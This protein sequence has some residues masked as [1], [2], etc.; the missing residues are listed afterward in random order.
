MTINGGY[1]M[2]KI[3]RL[4]VAAVALPFAVGAIV[5][6]NNSTKAAD[7]N[8][9]VAIDYSSEFVLGAYDDD[10]TA[11]ADEN[12]PEMRAFGAVNFNGSF[13]TDSGLTIGGVI[14]F[15]AASD[16]T[17]N[18]DEIYAY[19]SGDFGRLEVGDQDGAADKLGWGVPN[20]GFGQV[21]GDWSADDDGFAGQSPIIGLD[22]SSDDTK[23]T[24]YP[25]K[26]AGIQLGVSWSPLDDEGNTAEIAAGEETDQI[27]VG[28]SYSQDFAGGSIEFNGAW[29]QATDN[30][31]GDEDHQTWSIGATVEIDSI[32]VGIGHAD[33]GDS[34]RGEGEDVSGTTLGATYEQG[35][36]GFGTSYNTAELDAA[37]SR[38]QDAWS[39]GTAYTFAPEIN[40]ATPL[41]A[42]IAADLTFFDRDASNNGA[43]AE[44]DGWVAILY[45]AIEF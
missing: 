21:D 31:A 42:V 19:L 9:Y 7:I 41:E 29:F 26:M 25:P 13:V 23:I 8:D 43:T 17:N 2:S 3:R 24:Y 34:G 11:D 16:S 5:V 1:K 35:A 28:A 4:G 10:S 22:E 36:W 27:E 33:N 38:N 6:T 44:D 30:D 20:V 40:G 37:A 14:E 45:T 32:T 18:I 12:S 39:V 15:D